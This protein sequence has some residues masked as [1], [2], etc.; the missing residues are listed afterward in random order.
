MRRKARIQARTSIKERRGSNGTESSRLS[1]GGARNRHRRH[2]RRA[3]RLRA[4]RFRR[5]SRRG[6]IELSRRAPGERLRGIAR[7][8]RAHHR[9]RRREDVRRRGGRRGNGRRA[10][11]AERPRGGRDR[12][13]AAEGVEAHRPGRRLLGRAARPKRRAGRDELPARLPRGLPLARRPQAGRDVLQV[14]GRGHPLDAGAHGRSGLPALH[15]ASHGRDRIRGR[16]QMRA[17]QHRVRPEA[18]QQRHD[19]GAFGR[20]G[21]PARAWSSSTRR[22]ACSWSPTNQEP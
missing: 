19:G 22:R 4:C 11:R 21:P 8:R 18:V 9:H 16:Q 15:G 2:G 17:P 1:E 3:C 10:R 13:R 7:H 14:L 5:Q 6:G 12:R 20:A